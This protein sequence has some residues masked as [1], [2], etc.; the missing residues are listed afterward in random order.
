MSQSCSNPKSK[1]L[2]RDRL[3]L[4]TIEEW[5]VLDTQQVQAMFFHNMAYGQRKS[6]ERLLKLY[7]QGKLNRARGEDC[8][9][10]YLN[11][12][13]PGMVK[14]LLATNWVRL[15]FL[16]QCASWEILQSWTYE[17]DYRILRADGFASIKNNMTG[18]FRF[19]FVEM[20]RATNSFNKAVLYNKLFGQQDKHLLGKWWFAL[21]DVFPTILIVTTT[22]T[23]KNA[24]QGQIESQNKNNLVFT[25]KLLDDIQKEVM[26]KCFSVQQTIM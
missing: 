14:H 13:P 12:K 9:C 17:Q 7:R 3:I 6:Q 5:G 8:Y 22:N 1:G 4:Q 2:K 11:D 16:Q 15:W 25:V 24:I 19:A 23:R 21:T 20:D 26:E 18:K 10:Y